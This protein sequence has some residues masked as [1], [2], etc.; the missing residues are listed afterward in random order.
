MQK[1]FTGSGTR[2]EGARDG[3]NPMIVMVRACL[4]YTLKSLFQAG[5]SAQFPKAGSARDR[6]PTGPRE[7]TS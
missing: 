3:G 7:V 6:K 1:R 5:H 2:V 4:E